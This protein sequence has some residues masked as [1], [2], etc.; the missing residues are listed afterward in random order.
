[1]RFIQLGMKAEE[2]GGGEEEGGGG[3]GGGVGGGGGGGGGGY[4]SAFSPIPILGQP[5]V[6]AQ[7]F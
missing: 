6:S 7:H 2:W 1:M 3:G 5:S 4:R